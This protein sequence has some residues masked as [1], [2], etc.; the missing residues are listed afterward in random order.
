MRMRGWPILIIAGVAVVGLAAMFKEE[1]WEATG[2]DPGDRVIYA[3]NGPVSPEVLAQAKRLVEQ[4]LDGIPAKVTAEDGHLVIELEKR[5]DVLDVHGRLDRLFTVPEL[6]LRIVD[7]VPDYFA[8]LGR[9]LAR[10]TR[11]KELGV[12]VKHDRIGQHIEATTGGIY[13]N[14]VWA[15]QHDCS[16]KNRLTGTGVYCTVTGT[17]RIQ[18][19]ILGDPGLFVEPI[20]TDLP[21]PEDRELIVGDSHG[22]TRGYLLERAPIMIGPAMIANARAEGDRLIITLTPAGIEALSPRAS[23]PTVELVRIANGVPYDVKLEADGTLSL[24]FVD[25]RGFVND[26]GFASLPGRLRERPDSP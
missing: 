18:A 16:T 1:I 12:E 23:A 14:T 13:V 17:Q 26:L 8:E 22:T 25:A 24:A 19:F 2:H 21:F 6:E 20:V 7:Y 11:A 5:S 15:E 3:F 10:N 9:R 4:R